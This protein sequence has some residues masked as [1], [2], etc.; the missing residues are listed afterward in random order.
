MLFRWQ[1]SI[2]AANLDRQL[3]GFRTGSDHSLNARLVFQN[4]DGFVLEAKRDHLGVGIRNPTKARPVERCC[5]QVR[6]KR[7]MG[8]C[9]P[10]RRE[11]EVER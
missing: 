9:M 10:A 2:A 4:R 1:A 5:D 11:V 7:L 8:I 3:G 6:V